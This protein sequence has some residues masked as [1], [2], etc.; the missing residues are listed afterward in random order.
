MQVEKGSAITN[1]VPYDNIQIMNIGKNLFD[2]DSEDVGHV[3]SSTGSYSASVLWNTSDWISVESNSQYTLSF[4]TTGTSNLFFSE[5]DKNKTFIQRTTTS[6]LT[7]TNNTKYVRLSYKNDLG[8]YDIQIEKGSSSSSYEPCVSQTLNI[9]LQGN[10]LCSIGD[11][12]D[13]LDISVTGDTEINKKI[14]KRIFNG[15]ESWT[16]QSINS[17]D[18]ANFQITLDDYVGGSNILAMRDTFIPQTS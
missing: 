11:T 16:L 5:F 4:K 17:H 18:I 12:K 9:D 1:Y 10:E 8:T 6:I 3:Y 7:P 13:I 14:G 2:E 15:T